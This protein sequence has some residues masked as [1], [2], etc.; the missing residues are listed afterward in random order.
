MQPYDKINAGGFEIVFW[1]NEGMI[2]NVKVAK[3]SPSITRSYQDKE[4]KWV[5]QK[6]DLLNMSQLYKFFTLAAKVFDVDDKFR[7][8]RRQEQAQAKEEK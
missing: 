7:A 8:E 1:K 3:L 4:G 6:I 2:N 5:N